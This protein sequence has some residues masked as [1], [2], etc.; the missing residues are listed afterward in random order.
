MSNHQ[1]EP[2]EPQVCSICKEEFTEK[3]CSAY[4]VTLDRC[5]PRCDDLIVT[6]VRILDAQ[7]YHHVL[8]QFQCAVE[9]YAV[10]LKQRRRHGKEKAKE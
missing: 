2:N 6:P 8:V 4:P 1:G 10:I 5:C 7:G 9:T 3:S